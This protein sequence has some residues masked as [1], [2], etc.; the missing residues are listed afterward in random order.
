[1]ASEVKAKVGFLGGGNMAKAMA[2]GFIKS[3]TVNPAN[4]IVSATTEKTL[5]L[6]KEMG[7]QTTLVN[8][9][10]VEHSDVIFI[11]VKPN[12]VIQVAQE[13]ESSVDPS[14][15]LIVS[16]AVAITTDVIE[17]HLPRSRVIRC[18][19]NLACEVQCGIFAYCRGKHVQEKDVELIHKL[20]GTSGLCTEVKESYSNALLSVSGCGLGFVGL[21]MEAMS[22]GG[23][24]TGLPRALSTE[25]VTQ[26]LI[27]AARLVQETGKHPAQL[28]DEVCSPGGTTIAGIQVLERSG[29]RSALIDAVDA[30]TKRAVEIADAQKAK[31]K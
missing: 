17:A 3:K 14:K 5:S 25:L 20:L 9:E 28:K 31:E 10:V 8:K 15:H 24:R 19:P 23:V 11:A 2:K 30:A 22:D 7:C 21:V 26:T 29:L 13:I 1:M 4:I 16:I 18:L 12:L 27:G 6:W